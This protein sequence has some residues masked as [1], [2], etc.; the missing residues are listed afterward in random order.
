MSAARNREPILPSWI[1]LPSSVRI[2][3][4]V[5]VGLLVLSLIGAVL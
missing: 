2:A 4:G 1:E 5:A 3:V